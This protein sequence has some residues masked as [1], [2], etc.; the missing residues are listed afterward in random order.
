M[1]HAGASFGSCGIAKMHQSLLSDREEIPATQESGIQTVVHA[2]EAT[3][4]LPGLMPNN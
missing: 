3:N 2:L 4:T 1:L